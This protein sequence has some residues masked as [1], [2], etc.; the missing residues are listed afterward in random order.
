MSLGE[1]APRNSYIQASRLLQHCQ[2]RRGHAGLPRC[3][4]KPQQ[5]P[6]TLAVTTREGK[7]AALMS[8]GEEAQRG[9]EECMP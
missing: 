3:S 4:L 8:C 6:R 7:V 9:R 2:A 1:A 5:R